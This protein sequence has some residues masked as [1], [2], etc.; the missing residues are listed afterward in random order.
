RIDFIRQYPENLKKRAKYV[1]SDLEGKL[2]HITILGRKNYRLFYLFIR[3]SNVIILTTI[4]T[5]KRK[6]FDYT[7]DFPI[8]IFTEIYEDY[9]N[10]RK[11]KFKLYNYLNNNKTSHE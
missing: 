5:V 9:I 3:K 1:P 7:K 10:K 2:F 8:D 6:D 4:T 11:E